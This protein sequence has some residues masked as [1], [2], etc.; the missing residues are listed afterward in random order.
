MSSWESSNSELFTRDDV[1]EAIE[2]FKSLPAS[3]VALKLSSKDL[4]R[5]FIVNQIQGMHVAEKKFSFLL[6]Y[7]RII[8]P[9]KIHLEQSSS[10][11]TARFKAQHFFADKHIVD[12]TS[13]F[14]IDT[15]IA[16]Q[17]A[18][19]VLALDQAEH[20][21]K[22]LRHNA[23]VLALFNVQAK[24]ESFNYDS[25]PENTELVYLDPDRR[26]GNSRSASMA[27]AEP[28]ALQNWPEWMA[29]QR[30]FLLKLSPMMDIYACLQQLTHVKEIHVLAIGNEVKELLLL[31]DPH[32]SGATGVNCW[33][34]RGSK[35]CFSFFP[36]EEAAASTDLHNLQNYIYIP[37]AAIM[38]AG[39]FKLFAEKN[40]LK[41][42]AA[43]THLY[44]SEKEQKAMGRCY[45]VESQLSYNKDNMELIKMKYGTDFNIVSR[46]FD[47]Q[48]RDFVSKHGIAEGGKLTLIAYK[49]QE[50]QRQ[51][52]IGSRIY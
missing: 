34:L 7:D 29:G 2:Q 33:E 21:V 17:S 16:A 37:S 23:N 19:S 52:V 48:A 35:Q 38:K 30:Q 25:L 46:N 47:L 6:K 36:E 26:A 49:D 40:G 14:G 11:L 43:H 39:A 45:K 4:P 31:A 8:Y 1:L 42:L 13:G 51:I 10:E 22:G 9:P 24:C 44:T 32:Y 27:E 41:K 15:L 5:T 18:T 3:E 12:G 20:L 50:E 28:N